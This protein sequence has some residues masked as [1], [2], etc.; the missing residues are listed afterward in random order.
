MKKIKNLTIADLKKKGFKFF[1]SNNKIS[2][3]RLGGDD[4]ECYYDDFGEVFVI[5]LEKVSS[6]LIEGSEP[7][8]YEERTGRLTVQAVKQAFKKLKN[9]VIIYM[10][11]YEQ[12]QYI[13]FFKKVGFKVIDRFNNKNTNNDL[14][15]MLFSKDT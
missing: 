1:T 6:E 15:V 2:I 3:E 12:E 10:L 8:M 14:T 5:C 7:Q 4:D 11:D 9:D 13:K